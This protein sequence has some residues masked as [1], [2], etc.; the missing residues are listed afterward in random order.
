MFGSG[1]A[2]G[3]SSL[4]AKP[5]GSRLLPDPC[6]ILPQRVLLHALQRAAR[7]KLGVF[8]SRVNPHTSEQN[9]NGRQM[10][11]CFVS[12]SNPRLPT[13]HHVRVFT[14]NASLQV[15][16]GEAFNPFAISYIR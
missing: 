6:A 3:Q 4:Q 12:I 8:P 7:Y 2:G 15:E 1:E 14:N 9:G 13:A 10:Y 5:G 16:G 11:C